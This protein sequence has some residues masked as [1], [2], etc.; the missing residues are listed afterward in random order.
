[1]VRLLAEDTLL[2]AADSAAE[3]LRGQ[4]TTESLLQ[5]LIKGVLEV[6]PAKRVAMLRP[7]AKPDAFEPILFHEAPFS[8]DNTIVCQAMGE[9][10]GV[11]VTYPKSALCAPI[12]SAAAIY[13]EGDRPESLTMQHLRL[14]VVMAA[15]AEVRLEQ[16]IG[17]DSVSGENEELRGWAHV[18]HGLIG[19]SA[20]MSA[21]RTFINKV[22]P[23]NATV[24]IN[25]EMGTGKD[26]IARALHAL[27]DRS[28]GPF[29]AINC[30]AMP[31]TLIESELF[32]HERGAFSGAVAQKKGKVEIANGGTLFLDELGEMKLEAQA[33]L[34]RVIQNREFERLGG[35]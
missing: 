25:G 13:V 19:K 24:L 11:S 29:I 21:V 16:A 33:K 3:A 5:Q 12:G 9:S 4:R 34:L 10:C 6:I 23:S 15:E 32:G 20:A 17:F 28:K 8:V 2:Q 1:M 30:A 14:L 7:G 26:L 27:S 22:G 18:N 31:D 35:T